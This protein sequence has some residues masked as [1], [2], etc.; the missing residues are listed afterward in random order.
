MDRRNEEIEGKYVPSNMSAPSTCANSY[1]PI[2]LREKEGKYGI[3]VNA[4]TNYTGGS[5]YLYA[6]VTE[7][8]TRPVYNNSTGRF[9]YISS[10]QMTKDYVKYLEAGKQY[11]L[12]LGY[13]NGT[14]IPTK[15]NINSIKMYKAGEV[16]YNFI[17]NEGK[18]ESNNIGQDNT[19]ANSYIP[20]DLSS[21]A[22]K[23]NL[24][25]NAE[26]SSQSS[27]Y[28][29]AT[30]TENETRPL[31]SNS[32]G[33]FIYISGTQEAKDYSVVL[34]GG[35]MYY[36]HLGYYKNA[37][38]SSGEDKFT[39]N[40]VKVTLNDSELYHTNTATNSEGKAIT[41]I[42]FGKYAITEIKAP[43]GYELNEEP[44]I[45]EFRADENHEFTIE[46][47]EKAKVI[48][49]HYKA[50]EKEEGTYEYTEEKLL[51]DE[52]LEGKIGHNYVTT[53]KLDLEKYELIK[54]AE[55]NYI[56][57]ENAIGT[58]AEDLIE[59]SYYYE[60]KETP[61]IVHHYIEGTATPVLLKNGSSAEDINASGKQGSTYTT[62]AIS[63]EELNNEYELVGI[64]EN[65]EGTYGEEEIIV[66]YYYRKVERNVVI[67][68]YA[69][70]AKTL[71]SGAKFTINKKDIE[72]VEGEQKE[73]YTTDAEGKTKVT[74]EV[75][76]YEIREI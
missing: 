43:E 63:N 30:I 73:I 23:Y 2:D 39:V 38:T 48:V 17:E 69:K 21:C 68:K 33:R 64:P 57:P 42:P 29:Y 11:Y 50:T 9:M 18:Y 19:V 52:L 40:S 53:P 25:V 60:E 61:L 72:V 31:Y 22:G 13:N 20:I 67:K 55:E 34:Q 5:G 4:E 36:L 74:L 62:T 8:T 32:T 1:I 46:N 10:T 51:E 27:E 3:V 71:L 56:I 70:D 6:T 47:N 24:T 37:S 14:G 41:Q 7:N 28:G 54:D 75:G 45:V 35:K 26:V 59:V 65:A 58:F 76:A 15:V 16:I 66:T 12:H 44:V 49:H